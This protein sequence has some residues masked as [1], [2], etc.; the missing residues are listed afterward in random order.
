MDFH[1]LVMWRGTPGGRGLPRLSLATRIH[2][3]FP[4]LTGGGGHPRLRVTEWSLASRKSLLTCYGL[5]LSQASS[6]L[7]DCGAEKSS[8]M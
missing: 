3:I 5:R 6:V 1:V 7:P 8:R 2:P 4:G